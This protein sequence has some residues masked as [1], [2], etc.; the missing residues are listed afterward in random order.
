MCTNASN[1]DYSSIKS[2][3]WSEDS[4]ASPDSYYDD[5]IHIGTD[6]EDDN[7]V[8]DIKI[9]A[10]KPRLCDAKQTYEPVLGKPDASLV[11]QLLTISDA[12]H[13]DTN[14]LIQKL[15]NVAKVVDLDV[16]TIL[17]EQVKDPVLGTV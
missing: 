10:D 9:Q 15:D 1:T 14:G 2:L 11:K 16:S 12:F 6:S 17:A 4:E 3:S 5:S 8:C 13:L 7:I